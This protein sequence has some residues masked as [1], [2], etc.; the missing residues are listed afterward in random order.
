MKRITTIF[1]IFII[2]FIFFI[3]YASAQGERSYVLTMHYS[4]GTL[5]FQDVFITEGPPPSRNVQLETGYKAQ[6][7]SFEDKILDEFK[8][9]FATFIHGETFENDTIIGRIISD[10][11]NFTLTIPY[12]KNAKEIRIYSPLGIRVLSV[13]V[14]RFSD[15][16]GD[17]MCKLKENFFSCSVDCS[18]VS[19]KDEIFVIAII[20]AIVI[21]IAIIKIKKYLEKNKWESLERKFK[22][23]IR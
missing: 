16:C 4:N 23:K 14:S 8:F 3:Y 17:K 5:F 18:L 22:Y 1:S 2:T 6:L 10:K 13:D 11:V 20:V 9:V 21:I 15:I 7:I 19:P 12:F